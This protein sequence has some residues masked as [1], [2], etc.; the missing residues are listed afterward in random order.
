MLCVFC[1]AAPVVVYGGGWNSPYSGDGS[2]NVMYSSFSERPKYLDPGRSYSSNEYIFL[3]Q[4]YEPPLQYHYLKRPYELIPLT[5]ERM[6]DI[7]YEDDDGNRVEAAEHAAHT[8]YELKIRPGIRY[9]PHPAL[10]RSEEGAH[11]YHR[12]PGDAGYRKLADFEHHGTRELTAEDYVYQMKRLADPETHC[13]IAGVLSTHVVGFA[14]LRETITRMRARG[15]P[16]DLRTLDIAGVRATGHHTYQIRIKNSYP[17]FIY[18]LAMPFFSPMPWEADV[19][20][21]QPALIRNNVVLN[22]YPIGTGAYMLTQNDPNLRMVLSRNPY[23][24]TVYYPSEG[25][26]SDAAGGLLADAG[27]KVPFI[28]RVVF[29]LERENIPY[30]NKFLQGYYDASGVASD[31]FDQALQ[32]MSDGEFE[33]SQTMLDKGIRL[34]SVVQATMIYIGFNMKDPIVGHEG[35]ERARKL[36]HALSIA[37]DMEEYI[38]IFLNGRGVVAHGPIPPAIYG[39]RGDDFNPYT[40]RIVDGEVQRRPLEDAHRLLAEAGYADGIDERTGKQLVLY[41]DTS[42]GGPDVRAHLNWMRKQFKRLGIQLVIRNT[43]YNRFHEKMRSGA[44]QIFR[45]GWNADYP[46]PENFLFLLYGGNAKFQ[47]GE[48]ASNYNNPGFDALF[49]RLETMPDNQQ[50]FELIT[51]AV[52]VLRHDAPWI[53][54]YHPKA[55]SLHHEWLHNVKPH[56]MARNGLQY[57]RIDTVKRGQ[58]I[59]GW[60]TPEFTPLLFVLALL[61]VLIYAAARFYRQRLQRTAL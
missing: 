1:A 26:P 25:E 33:L 37:I 9:Q 10:A 11:L 58:R 4:I 28:D 57:R 5:L 32:V 38:S 16:V 41:F 21:R 56:L 29:S 17:Q 31:S 60:N 51:E 22:W 6:P 61:A 8:V 42:G 2:E 40:H 59:D 54:G 35:G 20:Y 7:F 45:W 23:Y 12:L 34:T 13:P 19:F 18:W 14:E 24:R 49:K 27:K 48:N 46:D 15:E 52:N 47:G 50:R 44:A 55:Y 39:H 36:R 43:D 30:W 53:W 3:A